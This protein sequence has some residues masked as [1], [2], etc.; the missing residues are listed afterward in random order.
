MFIKA[1]KTE[2]VGVQI[3]RKRFCKYMCDQTKD[4]YVYYG[5]GHPQ[6]GT[7]EK[8]LFLK[9]LKELKALHKGKVTL[10]KGV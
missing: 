5:S 1:K 7:K 9:T 3:D 4:M 10:M 2:F 6:K 8:T